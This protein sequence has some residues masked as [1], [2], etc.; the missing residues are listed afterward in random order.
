MQFSHAGPPCGPQRGHGRSH[1]GET[2]LE[3]LI[4]IILMGIGFSAVFGAMYTS[5]RVAQINQRETRASIAAQAVAEGLLQPSLPI[6][7]GQ[8]EVD[9]LSTYEECATA[10]GSPVDTYK[11]AGLGPPSG[12]IPAG[13]DWNVVEVRY[14][15]L[16]P[17]ASDPDVWAPTFSST[18]SGPSDDPGL[19]ELT[20]EV[21]N[22]STPSVT[23]RLVVI[24]RDQSCPEEFE[25][26]DRGPC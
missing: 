7:D 19:Q 20:I 2:L 16:A 4:A 13:W 8:P 9:Y 15:S 12:A 21:I 5:A 17:T 24:K 18:C 3:V 14:V 11:A 22:S 26:A 10:A 6:P 23:E 25:N 1:A